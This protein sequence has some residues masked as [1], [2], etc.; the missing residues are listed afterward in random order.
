M[1]DPKERFT[2]RVADY[3]RFRPGYPAE[4]LDCLA[5]D[6]GLE[7]GDSVADVGSGTGILTAGL[8]ARGLRVFAVEPN[9][10]MR[11]AAEQRLA[12]APLFV[13]VA[14]SAE[15]TALPDGSVD[16]VVAAQAFHW[17]DR[18]RARD[19]FARILRPGGVVAL[20]WND[21]RARGNSFLEGY[22]RLL[23]DWGIDYA[24][25]NH[26][27]VDDAALAA[28]F[29]PGPFGRRTFANAQALDLEGLR[30]RV[31]SASY[32]PGPGHPR[33]EPM[34]AALEEL[35]EASEQGG[36]VT[37]EYDTRITFGPLLP[38]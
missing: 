32:M 24:E 37:L 5:S 14:G 1:S 2:T 22:E 8:L 16:G 27:L 6:C 26:G 38:R 13:S 11:R 19:E 3:V 23:Q 7:A 35:F 29:S 31:L 33:H 18:D 30:G 17:F 21:R 36:L 25:V 9:E 28:F 20:I 34:L 4:L 12:A 15:A 10:A